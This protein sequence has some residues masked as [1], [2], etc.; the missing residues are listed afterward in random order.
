MD[1][2]DFL[3]TTNNK[4]Q[5]A[6]NTLSELTTIQKNETET[7]TSITYN[8]HKQTVYHCRTC[9][10]LEFIFDLRDKNKY[11]CS[12]TQLDSS[13]DEE[14]KTAEST[15]GRGG[16]ISLEEETTRMALLL[17]SISKGSESANVVIHKLRFIVRLAHEHKHFVEP[18]VE[19]AL[20]MHM[21]CTYN[22][23]FCALVN[24]RV[25]ESRYARMLLC[26]WLVIPTCR[27]YMW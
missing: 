26:A 9:P 17:D 23:S 18:C 15:D 22:R 27:P 12:S 6:V 3:I 5:S 16:S 13:A 10:V 24:L 19:K 4:K 8:K 14:T 2:T 21:L 7:Q 25:T 20:Y 1:P 11:L